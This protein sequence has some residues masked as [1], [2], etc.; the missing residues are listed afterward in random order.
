MQKSG[1]SA[2]PDIKVSGSRST[3]RPVKKNSSS[4]GKILNQI[5]QIS[6]DVLTPSIFKGGLLYDFKGNRTF[7]QNTAMI[8]LSLAKR[9]L[10]Q[11]IKAKV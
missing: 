7:L 5:H 9:L 4:I 2:Y 6:F 8:R 3:C 10:G 1:I 11:K